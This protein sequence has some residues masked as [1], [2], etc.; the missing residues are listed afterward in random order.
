MK[1]PVWCLA[2]ILTGLMSL[3]VLASSQQ[4]YPFD[5]AIK[6]DRF[7]SL[8]KDIRCVVC[9]N[10]NIADSNA[11]LANDLRQKVYEMMQEDKTD[12]DIKDY[13]AKRYGDFILLEPRVNP[14]TLLLWGFPFAGVLIVFFLLNRRSRQVQ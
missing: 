13:L 14:S 12:A 6:S 3:S 7:T 9:Q 8:I 4:T 1:F 5:T 10:Q 2:V 11:P